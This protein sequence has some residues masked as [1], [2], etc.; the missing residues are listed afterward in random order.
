MVH[1]QLK[2][3]CPLSPLNLD[4]LTLLQHFHLEVPKTTSSVVDAFIE[5]LPR[6]LTGLVLIGHVDR[7]HSD[8]MQLPFTHTNL[9]SLTLA[10]FDLDPES[11]QHVSTL[12]SLTRFST[13]AEPTSDVQYV[14]PGGQ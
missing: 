6:S 3:Q 10:G 8:A 12:T 5:V 4:H 13:R 2:L 1:L 14:R 11:L 7:Q 9:R